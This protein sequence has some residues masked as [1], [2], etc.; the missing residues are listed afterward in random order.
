MINKRE[1]LFLVLIVFLLFSLSAFSKGFIVIGDV[2]V[3]GGKELYLGKN[4]DFIKNIYQMN[5]LKPDE[6]VIIGDLIYGYDE[7]EKE[8]EREW[9][10]FER[11]LSLLRAKYLLVVGNHEIFGEPDAEKIY[12]KHAGKL[13][14]VKVYKERV[15]IFLNSEDIKE[16][17]TIPDKQI[18]FLKNTLKKYKDYKRKYVFLHKPLWWKEHDN[19]TWFKKVHPLLKEY[20]VLSVFAGHWHEYEYRK[21]DG[22]EYFVTGGGGAEVDEEVINGSI[23]HFVYVD[24]TKVPP[25]YIVYSD[26]GIYPKEFVKKETKEKLYEWLYESSPVFDPEKSQTINLKIKN[27]FKKELKFYIEYSE[28][29]K[30]FEPDIKRIESSLLGPGSQFELNFKAKFFKK[31]FSSYFPIPKFKVTSYLHNGRR[32]FSKYIELKY[33]ENYFS[34]S[35]KVL[36]P[37]KYTYHYIRYDFPKE[38]EKELSKKEAL[39]IEKRI[40]KNG[41]TLKAGKDFVFNFERELFPNRA[42]FLPILVEVRAEN[43][44]ERTL[45]IEFRERFSVYLN[46]EFLLRNSQKDPVTKVKLKL[47]KGINRIMILN[48]HTGGRWKLRLAL[49]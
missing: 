9:I 41:I 47:K 19:E 27:D 13:Y 23:F 7:D 15:F 4:L 39:K 31:E 35:I 37:H 22:I 5:L 32:Y 36:P 33:P 34:K 1:K 48:V 25:D 49:N 16:V 43:D 38:Y 2:R 45:I 29:N 30:Y 18:E 44:C 3:K 6:V 42:V 21:I 40:L 11:M 10:D 46:G 20:R 14:G 8:L 12:K 28:N 26:N 24:D 17:S